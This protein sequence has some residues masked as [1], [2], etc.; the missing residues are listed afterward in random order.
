MSKNVLK[1]KCESPELKEAMASILMMSKNQLQQ[2]I[3]GILERKGIHSDTKI[4]ISNDEVTITS[5]TQE[6]GMVIVSQGI[7]FEAVGH[8]TLPD[9]SKYM[10]VEGGRVRLYL[11]RPDKIDIA[12]AEFEDLDTA[13][14]GVNSNDVELAV[15]N[16]VNTKTQEPID[17]ELYVNKDTDTA[18][19]V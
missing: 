1:I 17:G 6:R 13:V 18:T 11:K 9:N 2:H 5:S 10:V 8:D 4:K 15:S 19:A 7:G 12:I 16:I 14:A 3:T